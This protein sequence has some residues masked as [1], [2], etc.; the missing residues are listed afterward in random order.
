MRLPG[1]TA[2]NSLERSPDAYRARTKNTDSAQG[3]RPSVFGAGLCRDCDGST[4][5]CPPGTF[6]VRLCTRTGGYA[7]C[8]SIGKVY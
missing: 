2:E 4:F 6:C 8:E 1:F 7:Y 3:V 5:R